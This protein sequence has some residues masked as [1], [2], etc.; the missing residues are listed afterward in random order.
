MRIL[1]T[2]DDGID[3]PGL[4]LLEELALGFS[5][6]VTI[7]AP[8]ANQSG[9]GRSISLHRDIDFLKCDER[10]YSVGGTPSDCVMLGL[11]LLFKEKLPDL[12]LSGI[13]HGMNIADDIGYSGTVGG[14]M[15]AAIAGIPAISI[16]QRFHENV[17]D[18]SPVRQTGYVIL[19]KILRQPMA[20]RTILNL[21]FPSAHLGA[22]KGLRGAILDQHK[23]SDEILPGDTANSYRF[24]SVNMREQVNSHTDRWWLNQGYASLTPLLIDA[25]AHNLLDQMPE[26]DF[27]L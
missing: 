27:E 4:H 20:S 17:P 24:G 16:S 15:A 10:H 6:D 1:V 14:A 12:V 25:N 21:N 5:D 2:N 8:M 18:F 23:S 3:A 26:A 9:T 7:I 13:N 22:V 19:E 11:N